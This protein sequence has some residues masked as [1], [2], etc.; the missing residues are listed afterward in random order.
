MF[1]DIRDIRVETL[2]VGEKRFD[3]CAML[4]N[5]NYEILFLK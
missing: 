2:R 5:W 1:S 3:D 4:R